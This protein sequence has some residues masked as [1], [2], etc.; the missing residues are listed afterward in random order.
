MTQFSLSGDLLTTTT[1]TEMLTHGGKIKDVKQV[2]V[3][4]VLQLPG[5][6][7]IRKF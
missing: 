2:Q 3:Y 7:M 5:Q 4:I 6:C 1:S